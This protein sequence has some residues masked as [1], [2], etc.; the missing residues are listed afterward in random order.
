[1]S[2]ERTAHKSQHGLPGSDGILIA[3]RFQLVL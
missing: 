1:V 3:K 2:A